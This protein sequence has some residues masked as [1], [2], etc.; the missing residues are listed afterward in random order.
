MLKR[1]T[2]NKIKNKLS[3]NK[4][5]I[6]LGS[7]ENI[8]EENLIQELVNDEGLKLF[9]VSNK[10]SK[11]N[12]LK[13]SREEFYVLCKGT[14]NILIKDAQLLNNLQNIIEYVLQSELN[15]NL[16]CL[17][18][19]KPNLDEV[20]LEVLESQELI[21]Q[22]TSPTF[23]EIAKHFGLIE[24]EKNLEQRLIFG[25][26]DKVF[27][28]EEKAIMYL[29][30][31]ISKILKTTLSANER[32]N[33]VEN[34]RL[35]LQNIALNIG[36]HI[37][38]NELALKTNLDNETVERYIDLL[39]KS[40]V[41]IK[42]K[43][44]ST[45]I[46]Y[47]LK[48]THCIYFYDNGIRNAFIKNFNPLEYRDDKDELWKNWFI[49]EKIKQAILNSSNSKFYFWVTHTKQKVDFIEM[50]ASKITAYQMKWNKKEKNKFPKSFID[51]Y[52]NINLKEIN[53]STYWSFLA[54]D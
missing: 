22:T 50:N 40:Q 29:N 15:L 19:N 6:L 7:V 18:S 14:K 46:K 53:R 20:L 26:H 36:N 48:K 17:C 44:Y 23:K 27:E 35:L 39:V 28:G 16:I 24:I 2:L 25:N 21:I 33:K 12:L 54:K 51:S 9:D 3:E 1:E 4:I 49:S 10:K 38:Y 45:D 31:C 42:L 52:P 30:L 11:K 32:I 8:N 13:I 34:L 43:T 37:S 41:L 47:E 5:L